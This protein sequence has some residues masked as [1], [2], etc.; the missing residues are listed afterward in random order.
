MV[1]I[2]CHLVIP[3]YN[4]MTYS[5]TYFLIQ[6]TNMFHLENLTYNA[7]QKKNTHLMT[8]QASSSY[9]LIFPTILYPQANHSFLPIIQKLNQ[10]CI[11]MYDLN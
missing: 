3:P 11:K 7:S 6:T 10:Y 8:F 2:L 9:V 4:L 5:S 1:S